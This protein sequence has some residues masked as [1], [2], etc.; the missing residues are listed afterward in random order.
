MSLCLSKCSCSQI[1]PSGVGGEQVRPKMR[2]NIDSRLSAYLEENHSFARH[3]SWLC[4]AAMITIVT[5]DIDAMNSV[6]PC[7]LSFFNCACMLQNVSNLI[8]IWEKFI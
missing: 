2:V 5:V 8:N 6:F 1:F 7:L 3:K 4:S